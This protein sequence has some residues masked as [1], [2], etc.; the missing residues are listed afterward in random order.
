MTTE[1]RTPLYPEVPTV[2]E[3]G[4]PGYQADVWYGIVLPAKAPDEIVARLNR[5]VLAVLKNAD[6]RDR[7]A[8]Q[9]AEVTGSTP[10][11]FEAQVKRDIAK[12]A[13]VTAR[14]DLQK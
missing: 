7:L 5:E 11:Q 6:V 3:S 12:W 10:E 8:A 1:K 4:L 14:L 13:K 2:A 9:G